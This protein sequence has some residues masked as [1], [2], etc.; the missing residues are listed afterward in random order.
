MTMLPTEGPM[1]D[2]PQHRL[3]YYQ[4]FTNSTHA[5]QAARCLCGWQGFGH[6]EIAAHR[7]IAR[8]S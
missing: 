4:H 5:I 7:E 8:A 2:A 6:E 3:H 1:D